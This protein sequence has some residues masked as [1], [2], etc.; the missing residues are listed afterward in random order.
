[1][2]GALAVTNGL[3]TNGLATNG[4]ATNGLALNGLATN[5]LST[6]DFSTW[7]S[8]NPVGYSDM[9]MK[10]VVACAYAEGQTLSYS[11]GVTTFTWYGRLGLTPGWAS[12]NSA[13]ENE[14]QIISACLAAHVNKFGAHVNIS[15]R[16][17]NALGNPIPVTT[18]ESSTFSEPEAAFFGNLFTGEGIYACNNRGPLNPTES[19]ARACGLSSQG[20]GASIEC[21]P[22]QHTGQCSSICVIDKLRGD[23]A[24]CTI[25][26]KAYLPLTTHLK[27]SDIY[28]CGDGTC[29]LSESCDSTKTRSGISYDNC[30]ADCG[31]CGA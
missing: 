13:T 28:K 8:S 3:A 5:G 25:G 20:T 6:T 29:Q 7:F 17:Q 1:M 16:G 27:P 18:S 23:Y 10:Y 12:G 30:N 31:V 24:R 19:S 21:P 11:N 22:I 4:L 26:R 2:A 15:I 9:V 14:Q